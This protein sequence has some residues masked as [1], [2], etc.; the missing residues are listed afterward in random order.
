[1]TAK[2]QAPSTS[3]RLPE[4]VRQL[5]DDLAAHM[6]IN[7][8]AVFVVALREKAQKEGVLLPPGEEARPAQRRR[9]RVAADAKP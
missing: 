5:W 4:P 9:R 3:L 6:G 7:K 2:Q 1:M 8:T